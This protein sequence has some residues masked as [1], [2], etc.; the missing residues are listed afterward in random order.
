MSNIPQVKNGLD[1][2]IRDF[3]ILLGD[4]QAIHLKGNTLEIDTGK[5]QSS[6]S[7][8]HKEFLFAFNHLN[9]FGAEF[10]SSVLIHVTQKQSETHLSN[11]N[12]HITAQNEIVRFDLIQNKFR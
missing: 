1:N 5:L 6:E 4:R 8:D 12:E 11:G 7:F 9:E 10:P 3:Q 2:P